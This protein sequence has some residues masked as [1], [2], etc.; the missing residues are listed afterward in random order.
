[1]HCL[2]LQN[3]ARRTAVHGV[4][5]LAGKLSRP[6]WHGF[7]NQFKNLLILVLIIAA[8]L[9]TVIGNIKQGCSNYPHCSCAKCVSW[10]NSRVSCRAQPRCSEAYA[11][12]E[13]PGCLSEELN[14]TRENRTPLQV[15]LDNL[16]KRLS[17]I[18]GVLVAVLFALD[19]L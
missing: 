3:I 4:N 10:P 14:D 2:G 11:A 12:A 7:L 8:G 5:R 15:Q 9:A 6:L 1:M 13:G 17:M 19:L 16:G 18:A